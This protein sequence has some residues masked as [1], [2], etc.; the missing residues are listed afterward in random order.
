MKYENRVWS[1]RYLTIM[2]WLKSWDI[3]NSYWKRVLLSIIVLFRIDFIEWHLN[4]TLLNWVSYIFYFRNY[5]KSHYLRN[6]VIWKNRRW[7]GGKILRQICGLHPCHEKIFENVQLYNCLA[8]L[9]HT[10]CARTTCNRHLH[11]C[12]KIINT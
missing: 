10:V 7:R 6:V 12:D 1:Y 5:L 9:Y 2:L 8:F 3:W 4:H 11:I